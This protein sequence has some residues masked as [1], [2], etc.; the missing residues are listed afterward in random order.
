MALRP[1]NGVNLNVPVTVCRVLEYD[2][3]RAATE[4]AKMGS[5]GTFLSEQNQ[6]DLKHEP[7]GPRQGGTVIGAL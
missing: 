5:G 6:M 2:H 7:D 4:W 3:H 1:S